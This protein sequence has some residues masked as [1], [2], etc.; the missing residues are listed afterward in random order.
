[1]LCIF[2]QKF[3]KKRDFLK[4]IGGKMRDQE[5]GEELV[6]PL[7][8]GPGWFPQVCSGMVVCPDAA[9]GC[10][11]SKNTRCFLP[12]VLSLSHLLR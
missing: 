9:M 5:T 3:L 10:M 4:R 12:T 7:W 2:Y 8:L 11:Y 1:M 6:M